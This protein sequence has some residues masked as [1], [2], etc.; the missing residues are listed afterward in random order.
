M[1]KKKEDFF[2]STA[3]RAVDLSIDKKLNLQT[4]IVRRSTRVTRTIIRSNQLLPT[5]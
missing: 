1:P 5:K 4:I 2:R 3:V